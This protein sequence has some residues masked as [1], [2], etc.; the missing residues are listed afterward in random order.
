MSQTA[1]IKKFNFTESQLTKLCKM[2]D[3][4]N[5]YIHPNWK[6][7]GF[8][9]ETAVN[10]ECLEILGHLGWK[11]WKDKTYKQGV[12]EANK[13]Q[14]KLELIDLLH[15]VVSSRIE[16]APDGENGFLEVGINVAFDPTGYGFYESVKTLQQDALHY[17]INTDTVQFLT[18]LMHLVDMTEQ[19]ILETYTQKYVLNKFRQD[20]GYKDG[21][22]VKEWELEDNL[23]GLRLEDNEVLAREVKALVLEGQDT[24]DET[25]LYERLELRY[26]SRLNK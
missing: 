4:L 19:E 16:N 21:S 12:T 20:H 26:N 3:E 6:W 2:Q 5:T 22:Y 1:Q 7:Q 25:I 11:W 9:W 8:D 18:R 23:G 14:I 15:F 24:T 10:D 17:G 13:A